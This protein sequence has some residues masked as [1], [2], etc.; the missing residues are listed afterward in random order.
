MEMSFSA[1]LCSGVYS[2]FNPLLKGTNKTNL[3]KKIKRLEYRE[4]LMKLTARR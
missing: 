2:Q 4:E 1:L 3:T